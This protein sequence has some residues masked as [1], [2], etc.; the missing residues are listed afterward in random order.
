[1]D[2]AS[3]HD[4]PCPS[5]PIC[6]P[7]RFA[8]LRLPSNARQAVVESLR[9]S[10]HA[11]ISRRTLPKPTA[12]AGRD[13]RVVLRLCDGSIAV[14]VAGC[15]AAPRLCAFPVPLGHQHRCRI[16]C[17]W[18]HLVRRRILLLHNRR[19]GCFRELPVSNTWIPHPSLPGAK[20]LEKS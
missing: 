10:R 9:V 16:G 17:C 4:G 14:N 5:H 7:C 15:T 12:K 20:I 18:C 2:R 3:P 11:R 6:K 19:W 1:M 13:R 8:P